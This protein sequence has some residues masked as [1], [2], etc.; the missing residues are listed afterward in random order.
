A[1][2]P[3]PFNAETMV[4]FTVRE[5]APVQAELFDVTGR[6]IRTLYAGTPAAG[7]PQTLRID[8]GDLPTGLYIVRVTGRDFAHTQRVTLLK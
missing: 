1:A 6:R 2:Y 3:N 8:G 7:T 4:R 5:A